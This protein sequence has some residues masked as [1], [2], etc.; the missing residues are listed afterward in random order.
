MD[1]PPW[2]SVS[3]VFLGSNKGRL[4][5]S[6][7]PCCPGGAV[8]QRA[9]PSGDCIQPLQ[10]PSRSPPVAIADTAP[11]AVSHEGASASSQHQWAPTLVPVSE[12]FEAFL[13]AFLWQSPIFLMDLSSWTRNCQVEFSAQRHHWRL[14]SEFLKFFKGRLNARICYQDYHFSCS[15]N[16]VAAEFKQ[17]RAPNF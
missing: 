17:G 16:C 5:D 8:H 14:S 3:L 11:A 13:L 10:P 12:I 15:P 9:Q 6:S 7:F 1:Q 2:S 4:D